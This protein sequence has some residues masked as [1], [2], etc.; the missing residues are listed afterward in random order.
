MSLTIPEAVARNSQRS[1]AGSTWLAELPKVV[2]Q[3]V[4]RWSLRVE[5]MA[6]HPTGT[7]SLVLFV[8]RAD[9][10][11]AVLKFGMPHME[12][13]H[14]ARGLG[15]WDGDP[16]VRLLEVDESL[17]AFL[18]ERCIP[19]T[20]LTEIPE[21][22]QDVVIT[23]L[24]SRLWRVTPDRDSFRPLGVMLEEWSREVIV[25]ESPIDPALQRQGLQLYVELPKTARESVLL[26]TDLHAGNVLKSSRRPWLM[27]DPKPFVGDPAYDLVQ[28]LLNCEGRMRSDPHG[29]IRRVADL[30]E[31][32]EERVALWVFARL[33]TGTWG[34]EG[35]EWSEVI[36]RLAP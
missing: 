31:Q 6:D 25:G 1:R 10:S 32:D 33:A 29:T 24:L 15:H 34:V 21:R 8:R 28:H 20:P 18:L 30:A 12:G 17:N 9:D 35:G 2:D 13:E 27:I 16:T 36:R 3:V 22:E 4:D 5:Q 11:L 14:E 7:A 23:Q 19:G 26:A